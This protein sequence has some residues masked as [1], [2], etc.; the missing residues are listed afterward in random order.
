MCKAIFKDNADRG[1][2]I[3]HRGLALEHSAPSSIT[4]RRMSRLY[5]RYAM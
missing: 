5:G 1:E 3:E 4:I 2:I